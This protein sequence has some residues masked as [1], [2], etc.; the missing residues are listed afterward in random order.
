MGYLSPNFF[1]GSIK[2]GTIENAS[3][4]NLGNNFPSHFLSHQK[5]NQGFGSINGDHNDIKDI[6]S[7]LDDCDGID[8]FNQIPN[9]EADTYFK[10]FIKNEKNDMENKS[11]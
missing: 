10:P 7:R 8:M 2:I 9:D 6:L 1:I 3:C 5:L 4:F 11:E